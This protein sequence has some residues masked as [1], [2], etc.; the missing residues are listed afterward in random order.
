VPGK[1]EGPVIAA[2]LHLPEAQLRQLRAREALGKRPYLRHR[3]RAL[4]PTVDV[5]VDPPARLHRG[6]R[7]GV[8]VQH[9]PLSRGRVERLISTLRPE[10][11]LSEDLHCLLIGHL[12][13]LGNGD[14]H[15][16]SRINRHDHAVDEQVESQRHEYH[17]A[18][19]EPEQ[20]GG[21]NRLGP[22]PGVTK[23]QARAFEKEEAEVAMRE[24]R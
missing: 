6:V 21:Q 1:G 19:P 15:A 11:L 23:P 24:G 20:R 4:R 17:S 9:R 8:L 16:L 22:P 13:D 10:P 12:P 3:H 5:E 18:Q 14:R 2:D 7:R